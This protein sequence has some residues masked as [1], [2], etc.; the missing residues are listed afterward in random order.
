MTDRT[1]AFVLFGSLAAVVWLG[2]V[3]IHAMV[4]AGMP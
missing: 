1:L 3:W 4:S 2:A